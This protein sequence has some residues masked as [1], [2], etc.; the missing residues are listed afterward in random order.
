MCILC[1]RVQDSG[2]ASSIEWGPNWRNRCTTSNLEMGARASG[3][4][5]V[6]SQPLNLPSP[7]WD[8]SLI[9]CQMPPFPRFVIHESL[10]LSM[11]LDG[12][13]RQEMRGRGRSDI[14]IQHFVQCTT[15]FQDRHE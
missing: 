4:F 13:G 14:Y 5:P 15:L 11:D 6:I 3:G 10:I 9:H 1:Q 7:R 12:Y 2:A 8:R